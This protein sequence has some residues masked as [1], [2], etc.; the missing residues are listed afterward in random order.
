MKHLK[1]SSILL[2]VLMTLA[3]SAGA[4]L[5][6]DKAELRKRSEARYPELRAAKGEG[7]IGETSDGLVE[8]VKGASL[9]AKMRELVDEENA[10]RRELYKILAKETDTDESLVARRAAARNIERA[11]KGEWI[12]RG[13]EWEQKR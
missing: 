5:A 8:A 6:A 13:G 3:L 10:D 4:A 9:D 2:S 12:K 7:K 1:L 11:G